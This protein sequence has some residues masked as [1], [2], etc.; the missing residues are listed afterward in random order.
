MKY[1]RICVGCGQAFETDHPRQ[2]YC[3]QLRIKKCR[4]CGK[5]FSQV[6]EAQVSN[7]CDNSECL[8][9]AR[10]S[11]KPKNQKHCKC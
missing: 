8:R 10:S 4:I 1:T 2:K 9:L 11:G 5:E 7:I 6:C 3:R